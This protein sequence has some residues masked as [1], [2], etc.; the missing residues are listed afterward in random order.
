MNFSI[1]QISIICSI[2]F[3]VAQTQAQVSGFI[4]Q[5]G[6]LQ[7]GPIQGNMTSTDGCVVHEQNISRPIQKSFQSGNLLAVRQTLGLGAQFSNAQLS[8][9]VVRGYSLKQNSSLRLR[10]NDLPTGNATPLSMTSND[11]LIMLPPGSYLDQNIR[12]VKI[13]VRGRVFI[14]SI[15][16]VITQTECQTIEEPPFIIPQPF[17]DPIP[18]PQ[19]LNV[20]ENLRWSTAGQIPGMFCVQISEGADPHTWDDNFLC[21][22]IDLGLQWSSAGPIPGMSCTQIIEPADPHTWDDNYLCSNIDLGLNWSAA[23]PIPGL[24]CLQIDEPAD[25]DYWFD[26]FLCAIRR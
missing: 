1:Q 17:P 22:F 25:P 26:N 16:A 14:E 2:L 23:S 11:N 24:D 5:N 3:M 9:L 12:S 21:S 15:T 8:Y 6:G 13:E 4:Q 20:I 18:Q 19:P 10:I 7:N